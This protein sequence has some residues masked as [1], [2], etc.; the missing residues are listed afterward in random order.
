VSAFLNAP[1]DGPR[2]GSTLAERLARDVGDLLPQR[3]RLQ[4]FTLVIG[5]HQ[6]AHRPTMRATE[7]TTYL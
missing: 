2:I 1:S 3:P 6:L 4:R 7:F 5:Q